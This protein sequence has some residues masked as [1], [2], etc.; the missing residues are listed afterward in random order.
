MRYFNFVALAG[1]WLAG[2]AALAQNCQNYYQFKNGGV[3][4]MTITN[5][6]GKVMGK[7][8]LKPSNVKTTAGTLTATVNAQFVNEKGKEISSSV[9][10]AKCNGNKVEIDM[11]MSMPASPNGSPANAAEATLSGD[12]L[13]YPATLTVGNSLPDGTAQLQMNNNGMATTTSIAITNRQVVSK[14]SVTTTAGTWNCFKIT[15]HTKIAVG[16]GSIKLP[17]MNTD[18]TEWYAPGFGVVRTES[19]HGKTELTLIQ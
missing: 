8:I 17:A 15:G 2:G 18:T 6:K 5:K 1:W 12:Y 4:E 11:R 9:Y 14:E 16:M 7:Q 19:D 3:I 10:Q 13:A